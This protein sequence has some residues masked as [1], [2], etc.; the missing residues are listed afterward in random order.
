MRVMVARFVAGPSGIQHGRLRLRALLAPSGL[1][2]LNPQLDGVTLQLRDSGGALF[3]AALS[4]GR[5]IETRPR[6]FSFDDPTGQL[7]RGLTRGRVRIRRN[8]A[9][10]F[11]AAGSDIDLSGVQAGELQ[12]TVGLGSRCSAGMARLHAKGRKGFVFP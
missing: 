8:G 2:D 4:P 6:S 11:R 5:W 1:G 9:V 10:A 12:L 7:A 3:C